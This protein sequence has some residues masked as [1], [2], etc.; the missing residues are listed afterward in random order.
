MTT[1][2]KRRGKYKLE[3]IEMTVGAALGNYTAFEDLS[4]EMGEWRDNMSGTSLESTQKF[5]T[6]SE[7]AEAL[8]EQKDNLERAVD[9]LEPKLT[10]LGESLLQEMIQVGQT[11]TRSKRKYPSREVRCGNATAP[12]SVAIEHLRNRIGDLRKL[13]DEGEEH[14]FFE[15][16]EEGFSSEMKEQV[17]S[18]LDDIEHDISDI[19]D[20]LGSLDGIEFPGMYG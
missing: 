6:V 17:R 18:D 9:E 16:D 13:L 3:T 12:I 8:E 4:I 15:V 5:G 14:L 20:A 10:E 1:T 7:T 2:K 11:I 19:D